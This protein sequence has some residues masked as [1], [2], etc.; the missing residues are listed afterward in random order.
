VIA[1]VACDIST[2]ILVSSRTRV[3]ET[4][5]LGIKRPFR[6]RS[7]RVKSGKV[8]RVAHHFDENLYPPRSKVL[9]KQ[10]R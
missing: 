6:G 2:I 1:R 4:P 7:L 10:S 3:A 8:Q 9:T 5:K